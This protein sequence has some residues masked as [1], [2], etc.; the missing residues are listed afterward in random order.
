MDSSIALHIPCHNSEHDFNS[1]K[2][3]IGAV[4]LGNPLFQHLRESSIVE[5]VTQL[6]FEEFLG[7]ETI[8]EEGSFG[9]KMCIL[10][11]T[12]F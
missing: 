2:D 1:T 12:H 9:E 11:S 10:K 6:R 7:G 5:I 3:L 8:L 4:L